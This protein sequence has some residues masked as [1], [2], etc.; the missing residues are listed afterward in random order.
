MII[1]SAFD[2]GLKMNLTKAIAL[3]LKTNKAYLNTFFNY[4]VTILFLSLLFS[5]TLFS[6]KTFLLNYFD[7]LDRVALNYAFTIFCF[8]FVAH[9]LSMCFM[10]FFEGL[11][12]FKS[13]F[14]LKFTKSL[15]SNLLPILGIYIMQESNFL[16]FLNFTLAG[17]FIG[18][19]ILFLFLFFKQKQNI[20]NTNFYLFSVE[21][22]RSI[23]KLSIHIFLNSLFG[24]LFMQLIN[25][26]VFSNFDNQV[27][28]LFKII[29]MLLA[30][31]NQFFASMF[32]I[33]LPIFSM[34]TYKNLKN[35]VRKIFLLNFFLSGIAYSLFYYSYIL[36][37]PLFFSEI[38]FTINNSFIIYL[39]AGYFLSTSKFPL[40]LSSIA[41]E[42][43]QIISIHNGVNF[44]I[45]IGSMLYLNPSNI[46]MIAQIFFFS[47]LIS[48]F[49]LLISWKTYFK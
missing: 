5:L 13:S 22:F 44:L 20:I 27:S 28:N 6:I 29:N 11:S 45:I 39:I 26:Y 15:F 10:T 49:F 42:N 21:N 47:Q 35:E 14:Y 17:H 7:N 46:V 33:I 25:I 36:L 4:L 37:I 32:M 16:L 23:L 43:P 19:L 2:L 9:H 40:V 41:F 31:I 34:E 12:D 30:Y 38:Q 48:Y 3:D 8:Y 18:L 1:G 24:I